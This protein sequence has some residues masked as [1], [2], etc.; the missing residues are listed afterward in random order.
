M[1]P[2]TPHPSTSPETLLRNAAQPGPD[3]AAAA[4]ARFA[5]RAESEGLIEVAYATMDSPFGELMLAA[6]DRGL[7]TLNLPNYGRDVSLERISREISPAI[8][9]APA[10][11]DP[12]RRELDEYFEGKRTSFGVEVDWRLIR[13]FQE[14]VLRA[15]YKV[16][17]GRTVTYGEIAAKAGNARAHR[18]AGTA[19]G[20]NPIPLVVPCHRI[21][22]AGG[23]PG[24]YGG[25]PEMKRALLELEGS[26]GE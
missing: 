15:T 11:L 5:A 19:L 12:V 26:L 18:A 22:R 24:S 4:A 2:K 6:T 1:S 21:T 8:L 9:E 10:R 25:G 14:K 7:V 20:R 23:L 17:Y 3:V 16:P 13:G